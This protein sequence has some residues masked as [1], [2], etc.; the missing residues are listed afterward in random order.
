MRWHA[1]LL[2]LFVGTATASCSFLLDF[3]ELQK[4]Q[5]GGD[6]RD[7]RDRWDRR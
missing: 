3:D 1:A 2:G 7:R 5:G 4:E 6:G